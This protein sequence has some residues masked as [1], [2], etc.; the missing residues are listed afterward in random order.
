MQPVAFQDRL[1]GLEL[2]IYAAPAFSLAALSVPLYLYLPTIYADDFG[3]GLAEVGAVLLVARLADA[4]TD[5]VAGLLADRWPRRKP[6]LLLSLGPM[7]MAIWALFAPSGPVSA[8]SLLGWSLLLYL[9][10]TG[11][12]V[13]YLA[14]GADL[15]QAYHGRT[16][17]AGAREAAVLAGTLVAAATPALLGLS[18][19]AALRFLGIVILVGLIPT[20][21]LACARLP[22]P[23]PVAPPPLAPK[24]AWALLRNNAPFRRLLGA[25]G[26]NGIAN[27][28]PATLFLSFISD[29]IGA[30]TLAG[31]ALAL[32]FCAGLAGVPGWSWLSRR[33]GK[34]R[35]WRFG[36]L[37]ACCAFLPAPFLGAGDTAG[38]LLL[39]LATGLMVGADLVLPPAMQ[40]DVI[41]ADSHA[42]GGAR[43]GLYFALWGMATKASLALAVGLAFPL[44]D[45]AGYVPGTPNAPETWTLA[46][47]Y[48]AAPLL[49]KLAAW[50]LMR[51]YALDEAA[52][53]ALR[54]PPGDLTCPAA[55][56]SPPPPPSSLAPSLCSQDAAR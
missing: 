29:R 34:H 36:L 39:C 6:W 52:L 37:G 12:S 18:G 48:G 19:P 16:R 11:F 56:F 15:N 10:W 47:L 1:A 55:G 43:A 20:V 21:L 31:P 17:V 45:W 2:A 22:E 40:A 41:E 23:R 35:A 51:G 44:L 53:A 9:G 49:F 33:L 38:F 28:L 50:G 3:L 7:A 13:P 30:P 32:Y 42:G 5:P 27:G 26:L 25:Y 4:L 8:A 24:Q 46:L 14:W 54:P